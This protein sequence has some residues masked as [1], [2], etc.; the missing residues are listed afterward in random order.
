[1]NNNKEIKRNNKL[2]KISA[3]IF[4]CTVI[5][6]LATFLIC[7]LE[8]K[9]SFNEAGDG[10]VWWLFIM[11]IWCSIVPFIV[12]GIFAIIS[13]SNYSKDKKNGVGDEKSSK[14][15]NIINIINIAI[16]AIIVIIQIGSMILTLF[17]LFNIKYSI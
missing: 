4:I 12:S 2:G 13:V 1:M 16:L 11:A 14:I 15:I 9:G 7:M 3:I 8:S 17:N 5:I 6:I 10:A